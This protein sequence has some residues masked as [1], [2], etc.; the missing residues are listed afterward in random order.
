[1]FRIGYKFCPACARHDSYG[2]RNRAVVA[3]IENNFFQ[4]S[5]CR[6]RWPDFRGT[7]GLNVLRWKRKK[8]NKRCAIR[9]ME[10][11]TARGGG[12]KKSGCFRATRAPPRGLTF[13]WFRTAV[14]GVRIAA[15]V[16]EIN[17][18][19]NVLLHIVVS[20]R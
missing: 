1:M 4:G 13:T 8:K 3:A 19:A 5:P 16:F 6:W 15:R 10:T 20:D 18:D 17:P 2:N 14:S 7:L 12:V 11:P 9:T